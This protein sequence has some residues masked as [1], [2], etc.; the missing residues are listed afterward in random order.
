M[1]VE[2]LALVVVILLVA[3]HW[4]TLHYNFFKDRGIQYDKPY[5]FFG[6]MIKMFLRQQSMFDIVVDLYNKGDG[7]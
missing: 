5:P 3:Y 7:K 2:L 6:S 1:L 4:A